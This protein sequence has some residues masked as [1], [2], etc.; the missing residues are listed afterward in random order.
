MVWMGRE[1]WD[2]RRWWGRDRTGWDGVIKQG[3]RLGW[4][5]WMGTRGMGVGMRTRAMEYC[6]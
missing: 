3:D 4:G 1:G 6:E 5:D 2:K